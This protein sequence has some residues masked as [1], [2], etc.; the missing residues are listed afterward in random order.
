MTS[1]QG[2]D[3][4]LLTVLFGRRSRSTM[5]STGKVVR[6]SSIVTTFLKPSLDCDQEA[7]LDTSGEKDLLDATNYE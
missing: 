6:S 4:L 7:K 2:P 1:Q 3:G 5:S